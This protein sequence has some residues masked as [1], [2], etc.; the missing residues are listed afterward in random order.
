MANA[1]SFS[2]RETNRRYL[3]S[4][5]RTSLHCL[6]FPN[7]RLTQ[8][9]VPCRPPFRTQPFV[10]RYTRSQ[11]EGKPVGSVC[12]RATL[13]ARAAMLSEYTQPRPSSDGDTPRRQRPRRPR[14]PRRT[15]RLLLAVP[16]VRRRDEPALG[17]VARPLQ[18]V[19]LARRVGRHPQPALPVEREPDRP[20][21]AVRARRVARVGHDRRQRVPA[22]RRRHRLAARRVEGHRRDAVADGRGPVDWGVGTGPSA[23]SL[24][25]LGLSWSMRDPWTVC[26]LQLPRKVMYAVS[27]SAEN[28]MS[29]GA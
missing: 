6:V 22:P 23:G 27:P 3:L 17:Q 8:A 5:D 24:R 18:H 1:A 2:R 12:S 28:L 20:E 16:A 13:S 15:R 14:P 26:H 4:R 19:D 9:S 7:N 11:Y 29:M 21:A 10:P 25:S